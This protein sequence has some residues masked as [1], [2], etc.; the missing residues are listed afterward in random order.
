MSK[1]VDN[2]LKNVKSVPEKAK[3]KLKG[4]DAKKLI[5]MNSPLSAGCLFS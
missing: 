3:A 4:G 5:L 1:I 2:I